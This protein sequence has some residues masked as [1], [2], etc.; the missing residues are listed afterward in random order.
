MFLDDLEGIPL[1]SRSDGTPVIIL[2]MSSLSYTTRV[3]ERSGSSE[4]YSQLLGSK[5]LE[6]FCVRVYHVD[7]CARLSKNLESMLVSTT[8]VNS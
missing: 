5:A 1:R 6:S 8:Y 2:R 4:W 7:L 3:L